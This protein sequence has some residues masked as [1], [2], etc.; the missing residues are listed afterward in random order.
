MEQLRSRIYENFS[1]QD[2]RILL[3]ICTST[4]IADNNMK[5]K[6]LIKY[7]EPKGFDAI[8]SGTNRFTMFKDGYAF[9]FAL[10]HY[11]YDD[12]E[13]EFNMSKR[14]FPFGATKT[15]ETNGLVNV[16]EF[17]NVMNKSIFVKNKKRIRSILRSLSRWF[18]FADLGTVAR[19]YKNWG[20]DNYGEIR[21]LDYGL[22]HRSVYE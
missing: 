4:K 5:V 18:L 9:K 20:F 6:L 22:I 21:F 16:S 12:N 2:M 8:G 14:L 1:E 7:L 10:D 13:T 3:N 17:V 15:Y 11:G 19:N